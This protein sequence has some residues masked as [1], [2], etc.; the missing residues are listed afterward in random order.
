MRPTVAVRPQGAHLGGTP[1]YRDGV[2]PML[3]RGHQ[4][5]R[6]KP[7]LRQEGGPGRPPVDVPAEGVGLLA[8]G[9]LPRI[10]PRPSRR[11][12]GDVGHSPRR[13]CS[14]AGP[15]RDRPPSWWTGKTR[16]EETARPA[17]PPYDEADGHP[18]GGMG[19]GGNRRGPTSGECGRVMVNDG[20]RGGQHPPERR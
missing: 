13:R 10:L 5:V 3:H 1:D 15:N 12:T 11:T 14:T 20:H 2:R 17:G 8:L 4:R 9:P 18:T 16:K 19:G 6:Q 7:H